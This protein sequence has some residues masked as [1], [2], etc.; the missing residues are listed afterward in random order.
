MKHKVKQIFGMSYG[1]TLLI[2]DDSKQL[3]LS[4]LGEWQIWKDHNLY[5]TIL[6]IAENIPVPRTE[7]IRVL[8]VGTILSKVDLDPDKYLIEL[9]NI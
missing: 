8:E 4:L 1:S 9:S 6:V 3:P 7:S 5:D 2:I